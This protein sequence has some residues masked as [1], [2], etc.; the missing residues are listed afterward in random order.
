LPRRSVEAC[1]RY[2]V[3]DELG[4]VGEIVGM[5]GLAGGGNVGHV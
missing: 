1:G 5:E 3:S 2:Q 4:F